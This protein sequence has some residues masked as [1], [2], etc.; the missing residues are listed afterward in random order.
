MFGLK[1]NYTVY[2][3]QKGPRQQDF[4]FVVFF[5]VDICNTVVVESILV[6]KK[7]PPWPLIGWGLY[8]LSVKSEVRK[9]LITHMDYNMD[10]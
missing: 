3:S 9:S 10:I 8:C 6:S 2:I 1:L 7:F 4:E 5:K